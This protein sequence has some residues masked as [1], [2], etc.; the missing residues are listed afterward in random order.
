MFIRYNSTLKFWEYDT[1]SGSTGAGPWLL[2]PVDPSKLIGGGAPTSHHA[3]HET[4]GSDALV[5]LDGSIIKT[6]TVVD[7]RLSANVPLLN[8]SNLFTGTPQVIIGDSA[9]TPEL[10]LSD[11]SSGLYLRLL[12]S[13]NRFHVYLNSFGSLFQ[14]DTIGALYERARTTAIGEWITYNP[15]WN[16][17]P[18]GSG[19]IGN[20]VLN[21]RYS[22]I[23]KTCFY[24]IKLTGGTTTNFGGSGNYWAFSLPVSYGGDGALTIGSA[25]IRRSSDGGPFIAS[26]VSGTYYFGLQNTIGILSQI[27][28]GGFTFVSNAVPFNWASGDTLWINGFYE[29]A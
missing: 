12:N 13:T 18:S 17:Y 24:T 25:S 20:G 4:G 19:V 1:S 9:H 16:L 2:L 27:S 6:G 28:S 15:V 8:K 22:L 26:I 14:V 5:T 11:T 23:G 10:N 21:G 3:T 7:A 29:I